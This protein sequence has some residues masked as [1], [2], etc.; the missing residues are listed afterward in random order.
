[1]LWV[2]VGP[3]GRVRDIRVSRSLGMGLDEKAID[4]VRQWR[5]EPSRKDGQP[6]PVQVSIE[7][8]F[9]LY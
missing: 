6:V 5:F 8:N 3:D 9:R 4:A 2:V 7:V 1:V